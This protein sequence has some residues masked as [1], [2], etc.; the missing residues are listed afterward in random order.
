MLVSLLQSS[1]VRDQL[2]LLLFEPGAADSCYALMLN[3][4]HSDHLRELVFKV[5]YSKP[6]L[7][8]SD[9]LSVTTIYKLQFWAKVLLSCSLVDFSFL[10]LPLHRCLNACCALTVSMRRISS[11]CGWGSQATLVYP[12]CSLTFISLPLLFDVSWTRSSTQVG[13]FFLKFINVF[14]NGFFSVSSPA[15]KKNALNL[16]SIHWIFWPA[17]LWTCN[18]YFYVHCCPFHI[19]LMESISWDRALNQY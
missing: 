11:V 3:N 13:H 9:W 4:K 1:P 5:G 6:Y 8:H 7:R 10:S 17:A 18:D 2:F 15:K 16:I 19:D 14:N 12:C